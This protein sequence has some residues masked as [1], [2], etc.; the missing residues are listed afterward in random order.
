MYATSRESQL[1]A[2]DGLYWKP[3]AVSYSQQRH[4]KNKNDRN[5]RDTEFSRFKPQLRLNST[6]RKQDTAILVAKTLV[7]LNQLHTLT[8]S[9]LNTIDL[10]DGGET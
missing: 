4:T 2:A 1:G 5:L 10:N 7:W 6:M 8:S 9:S 3:D